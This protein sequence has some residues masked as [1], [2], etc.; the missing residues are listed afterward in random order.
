MSNSINLCEHLRRVQAASN[1]LIVRPLLMKPPS[2]SADVIASN[3]DDCRCLP[4]N[5]TFHGT[6]QNTEAVILQ[7]RFAGATPSAC[8]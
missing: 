4:R 1:S 8:R 5:L 7:S 6:I 2:A 3:E